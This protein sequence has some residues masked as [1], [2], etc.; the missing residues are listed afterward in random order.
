MLNSPKLSLMGTH[1]ASPNNH[2]SKPPAKA[3]DLGSVLERFENWA[4]KQQNAVRELS[5]AEAIAR[6]RRRHPQTDLDD[7]EP[8]TEQAAAAAVTA[9]PPPAATPSAAGSPSA[10]SP[11]VGSKTSA[12]PA[13]R[14]VRVAVK[15]QQPAT[16]SAQI[17]LREGASASKAAGRGAATKPEPEKAGAAQPARRVAPQ[18]EKAA[19]AQPGKEATAQPGKI[20]TPAGNAK[21]AAGASERKAAK[22]I[23]NPAA[24]PKAADAPKG[25][26][27]P[28]QPATFQQ[29]LAAQLAKSQATLPAEIA[30]PLETATAE[31][32]GASPAVEETAAAI[33]LSVAVT[34]AEHARIQERAAQLGLTPGAYLRQCAWE[35]ESLRTEVQKL[36]LAR[37]Q[38]GPRKLAPIPKSSWLSRLKRHFVSRRARQAEVIH[39]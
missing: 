15:S 25:I 9:A 7:T 10:V 34:S 16:A 36:L 11:S 27:D 14:A 5:Y 32:Q 18:P 20:A 21:K 23:A 2:R 38:F 35:V 28:P 19:A 22:T 37:M 3:E 6:S 30:I 4:G 24:P 29:A 1:T 33:R 12:P 8:S 26:A 13:A 17:P 31:S 39:A